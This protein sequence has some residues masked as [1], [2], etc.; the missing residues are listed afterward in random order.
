MTEN[1]ELRMLVKTFNK[2]HIKIIMF[3]SNSILK[4]QL[5]LGLRKLL[6][7]D[8]SLNEIINSDFSPI[9][10]NTVYRLSDKYGCTYIYFRLPDDEQDMI[11][12]IGPFRAKDLSRSQ[13][14]DLIEKTGIPA[15]L[16]QEVEKY[17]SN[18]PFLPESSHLFVLLD[19]FCEET[20]GEGKYTVKDI[21]DHLDEVSE[22][23]TAS[24]YPAQEAMSW[25]IRLMEERYAQENG[26]IRAVSQGQMTKAL[27]M[28]N[29]FSAHNFEKRLSDNI[30]NIKNYCIIMNTLLRKAAETGGVHPVYLDKTSSKFAHQIEQINAVEDSPE[31]MQNM[32]KNYCN[33]VKKHS[34]KN[35][36]LPV[37]RAITAIEYDLTADLSLN[38]IATM[39]GISASYLSTIFKKETGSTLTDHVNKKR[40]E[41]AMKLLET[42]NIQIQTVAQHCGI[43][44][45][46]YFSRIFKKHTGVTPRTYRETLRK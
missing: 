25:K 45:V 6:G 21:S 3:D 8:R 22:W 30:R 35:Y 41:L 44:D 4:Q 28:M 18:I 32:I 29:M 2:C 19:I 23:N 13:I 20:W 31:I 43:L 46:H 12:F 1:T 17:Y 14:L 40:I 33:L 15:R 5:D 37:Q 42:T 27:A 7:A 9:A 11:L 24:P 10:S 26:M 39:Q 16:S 36:S 34:T 38:S